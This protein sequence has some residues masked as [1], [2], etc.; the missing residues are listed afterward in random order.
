MTILCL[1]ETVEELKKRL[2]I[3]EQDAKK[4]IAEA[5]SSIRKFWRNAVLEGGT[6]GGRMLRAALQR[7]Q[8]NY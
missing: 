4:D 2:I 3:Q 6:Y 1:R 5:V 8:N 7:Q